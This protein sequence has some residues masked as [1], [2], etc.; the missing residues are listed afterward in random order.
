MQLSKLFSILM[1]V[2][3]VFI[4]GCR[5]APIYNVDD[6]VIPASDKIT[7]KSVKDAIIKAGFSLGWIMD[8]DKPGHIIGT[9]NLRKHVAVVDVKY[10]TKSYSITYKDSTELSY[11]G[12]NIHN[13]YN[14]WVQNLDKR[15]KLHL[16]VL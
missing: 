7:E 9:L 1:L 3:V 4:S 11:D 2:A 10:S 8:A 5:T 13:N 16:S 15:I 6:S 12:T 14:S